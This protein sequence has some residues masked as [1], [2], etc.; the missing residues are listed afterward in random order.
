MFQP[1]TPSKFYAQHLYI[2]VLGKRNVPQLNTSV[3]YPCIFFMQEFIVELLLVEYPLAAS[4]PIRQG[5]IPMC[6]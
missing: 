1:V 6:V 4:K 2:H 5:P 3:G